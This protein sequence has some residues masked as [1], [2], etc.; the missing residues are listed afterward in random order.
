MTKKISI[1]TSLYESADYVEELCFRISRACE[2]IRLDFEIILV[3][4]AS[5]DSSL[6][7]AKRIANDFPNIIVLNLSRNFGQHR[8]LIAGL[9]E[10][11]GDLVYVCD[12]D[13][14]EDPDWIVDFYREM[15]ES[16][17]DVVYGV[18]NVSK[19]GLLYRTCRRFFY[20]LLRLLSGIDFPKNVVTAR[21]MTR[22]YVNAMLE[23]Q[24]REIFLTG[25][26]HMVGFNQRPKSV[27]KLHTSNTSYSRARLISLTIN[28]LVAFSSRPLAI[29]AFVGF[30]MCMSSMMLFCYVI[31]QRL[32][33]GLILDGWTSIIAT[34]LLS[35]GTTLLLNGIIAVY[36]AKIYIEVKQRP[37]VTIRD[38]TKSDNLSITEKSGK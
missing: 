3:N 29:I 9:R 1:V 12:S 2:K 35:S 8:A 33:V 7:T 32:V 28:A 26:W 14:E 19:R 13:L 36:I 34:I 31:Y 27:K 18:Q 37:I 25:I 4:D 16:N 22:D 11:C 20:Y 38:I 17:A 6:E 15:L 10:S 23:Y 21:L 5:P 24:E 30:L